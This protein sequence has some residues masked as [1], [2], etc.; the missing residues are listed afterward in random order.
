[1]NQQLKFYRKNFIVKIEIENKIF[2]RNDMK[3]KA[4]ACFPNWISLLS[5]TVVRSDQLKIKVEELTWMKLKLKFKGITGWNFLGF[6][7][8]RQNRCRFVF[9]MTLE[10]IQEPF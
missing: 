6:G 9:L 4:V 5:V 7:H 8:V 3:L 10:G 2:S 1:M